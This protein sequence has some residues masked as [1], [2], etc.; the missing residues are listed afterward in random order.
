MRSGA[1]SVVFRVDHLHGAPRQGRTRL[2]ASGTDLLPVLEWRIRDWLAPIDN[3]ALQRSD[4]SSPTTGRRVVSLSGRDKARD[5][6]NVRP[7]PGPR[8]TGQGSATVTVRVEASEMLPAWSLVK[9]LM[10]LTPRPPLSVKAV[11]ADALQLPLPA[12]GAVVPSTT[13]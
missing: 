2:T 1:V 5:R 4:P 9:A 7:A 6:S 10:V 13:T 8:R 3:P 11:G 12:D